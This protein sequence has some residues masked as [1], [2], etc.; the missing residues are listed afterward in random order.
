[1]STHD[2][3]PKI[4]IA[5]PVPQQRTDV[6]SKAIWIAPPPLTVMHFDVKALPAMARELKRTGTARLTTTGALTPEEWGLLR[7]ELEHLTGARIGAT[8]EGRRVVRVRI[9]R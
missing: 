9:D 5:D 1:M 3:P 8:V 2:Q 4:R 7:H 6:G